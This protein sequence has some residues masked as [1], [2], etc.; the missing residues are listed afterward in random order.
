MGRWYSM[1]R[2]TGGG[3]ASPLLV[4]GIAPVSA[5]GKGK[6]RSSKL[7]ARDD[8]ACVG[9]SRGRR[10]IYVISVRSASVIDRLNRSDLQAA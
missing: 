2:D 5:S 10:K 3:C 4:V 1:V 7:R 6:S 9:Y 8:G